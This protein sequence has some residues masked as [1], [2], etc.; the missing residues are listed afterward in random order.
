MSLFNTKQFWG[1]RVGPEEFD[2]Q[3]LFVDNSIIYVGSYSGNLRIYQPQRGDYKPTHLKQEINLQDPILQILIGYFGNKSL[4]VLFPKRV[5]F[6]TLDMEILKE[7]KLQRNGF[8]MC[9]GQFGQGRKDLIC[10]QSCDACLMIYE[11]EQLLHICQLSTEYFPL[12]GP[13]I[14]S[15]QL[16]SFILQNS[17]YELECYKYANLCTLQKKRAQPNWTLNLGEQ[18]QK[19]IEISSQNIFYVICEQMLFQVQQSGIIFHQKR[20]DYPPASILVTDIHTLIITSFTHHLMIYKDLNLVWAAKTDHVC[21]GISIGKFDDIDKLL[22]VLND[23]GYLQVIFLGTEQISIQKQFQIEQQHSYQQLNELYTGTLQQIQLKEGN[24]VIEQN[25]K[26]SL[27]I[28]AEIIKLAPTRDYIEDKENYLQVESLVIQCLVYLNITSKQLIENLQVQLVYD[29]SIF[30]TNPRFEIN[31]LQGTIIHEFNVYSTKNCP[32]DRVVKVLCNHKNGCYQTEFTL[33]L[34]LF[35]YMIQPEK[36]A[37][38]RIT[39][40]VN[41]LSIYNTFKDIKPIDS[42]LLNQSLMTL[43][44]TNSTVSILANK[45]NDR[46]R[47]QSDNFEAISFLLHEL[48]VRERE[49]VKYTEDVPL[50][51]IFGVIDEHFTLKLSLKEYEKDLE[52]KATEFRAIQKKILQRFKENNP[53]SVESMNSL[54]ELCFQQFIQLMDNTQKCQN[55]FKQLQ[56]NLQCM[57]HLMLLLCYLRF[58]ITQEQLEELRRLFYCDKDW[59]EEVFININYYLKGQIPDVVHENTQKIKKIITMLIDKLSKQ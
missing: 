42:S 18:A 30:I 7:H 4:C 9:S 25:E 6:Y 2:E 49:N 28:N 22:V 14:Y 47:L 31:V 52:Q 51:D 45:Q 21:H 39:V 26:S 36:I 12:P 19:I 1:T 17:C 11:Q 48:V 27:Q 24:P 13:I 56:H 23:E 37:K 57:I 40:N 43:Q 33:P 59:E 5:V 8:N 15:Q 10:I 53:A 54:L 16:D 38:Y 41:N 29:E 3:H 32:I 58:K 55:I 44:M 46:W 35:C 50:K 20:L 34:S